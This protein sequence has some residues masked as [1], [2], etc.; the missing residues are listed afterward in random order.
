[1]QED[2]HVAVLGPE[3]LLL[4]GIGE[5]LASLTQVRSAV[6]HHGAQTSKCIDIIGRTSLAP[7]LNSMFSEVHLRRELAESIS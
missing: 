4:Q 6:L 7:V 5:E 2:L 3:L 1:V